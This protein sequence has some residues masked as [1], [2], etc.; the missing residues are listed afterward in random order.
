V[1]TNSTVALERTNSVPD[2][3]SWEVH[4]IL[5]R[6]AVQI[7]PNSYDKIINKFY[8]MRNTIFQYYNAN[9]ATSNIY[10]LARVLSEK[11]AD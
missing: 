4:N 1:Y 2:K 9:K 3:V 10:Q 7:F 6:C 11:C 8:P 5:L